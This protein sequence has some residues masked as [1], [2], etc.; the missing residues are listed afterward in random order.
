M[1]DMCLLLVLLLATVLVLRS[2]EILTE[3]V[4]AHPTTVSPF[5]L[6]FFVTGGSRFTY[7]ELESTLA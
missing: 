2:R 5:S 1:H 4:F 6:V 7:A 3:R